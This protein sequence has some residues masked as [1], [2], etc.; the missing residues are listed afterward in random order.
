MDFAL[1]VQ[2]FLQELGRGSD[3]PLFICFIDLQKAAYD[4]VN[5]KITVAIYLISHLF[6]GV[7][8]FNY[9]PFEYIEF[10]GFFFINPINSSCVGI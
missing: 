5:S 9:L 2:G 3:M 7:L 8:S 4:R 6:K 10:Y 1:D